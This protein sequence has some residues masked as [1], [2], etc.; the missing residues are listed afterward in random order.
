MIAGNK[1]SR[2]YELDL[3]RG[4]AALNVVFFHYT[5][6]FGEEFGHRYPVKYD[7]S[8]GSYGVQLFFV[9]SGFVIFLTLQNVK[10]TKEFL[11]KRFTRLYPTYWISLVLT[12]TIVSI[13]GLPGREVSIRD[14]LVGVTMLQGL[15]GMKN[16]DGAYWSLLPELMFY[17]LMGI[18]FA[19]KLLRK[20][21]TIGIA[22]MILTLVNIY[23]H[24]PF[25]N[26][27]LNLKFA[28]FFFAGII[29]FRI[30]AEIHDIWDHFIILSCLVIAILSDL[31]YI[32]ALIYIGIFSLFYLFVYGK[33]Q[34]LCNKPLI[35]IGIISYPLYLIHQNIGF[36]LIRS[37]SKIISNEILVIAVALC[38]VIFLAWVIT[39]YLEYPIM[40]ILRKRKVPPVNAASDPL[41][42][43]QQS[44]N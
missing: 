28:M 35:F 1:S 16:V 15:V 29:F 20:V 17:L 39:R 26:I 38:I 12:F 11:Y 41:H 4:L 13:A 32:P 18:L 8:Y 9:I 25:V 37:L 30:K 6:K 5:A 21:R 27:L 44:L 40:L 34:R 36:V 3:L 24:V 2:L 23:H 10:T 33:L 31:A 22:W 14:A 7:W 43:T 19:F 42:T